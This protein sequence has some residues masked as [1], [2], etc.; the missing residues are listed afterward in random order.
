MSKVFVS[1][2]VKDKVLRDFPVGQK[3]L[4][5]SLNFYRLLHEGTLGHKL[6]NE[7]P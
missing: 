4:Q 3:K 6:E 5:N 7:Q 2:A 1:F